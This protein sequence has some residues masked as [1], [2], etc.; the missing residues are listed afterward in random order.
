MDF[1]LYVDFNCSLAT[2]AVKGKSSNLGYLQVITTIIAMIMIIKGK[3]LY[4]HYFYTFEVY[5]V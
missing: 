2:K 3:S 4:P 1:N 5:F